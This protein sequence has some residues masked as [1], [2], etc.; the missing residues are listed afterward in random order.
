MLSDLKTTAEFLDEDRG[1][2]VDTVADFSV[3]GWVAT[4][5]TVELIDVTEWVT[6]VITLLNV[7]DM[8]ELSVA[9]EVLLVVS[10]T[11]VVTKGLSDVTRCCGIVT[12][13]PELFTRFC[14]TAAKGLRDMTGFVVVLTLPLVVVTLVVVT[15]LPL[16]VV[17]LLVAT[18]LA[19]VVVTLLVVTTLAGVVVVVVAVVCLPLYLEP[20]LRLPLCLKGLLSGATDAYCLPLNRPLPLPFC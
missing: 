12:A 9:V 13:D 11:D 2:P 16:V 1:F 4:V 14:K 5:V 3:V 8:E 18:T 20:P 17:T 19:G 7:V 15:R 10:G 6:V